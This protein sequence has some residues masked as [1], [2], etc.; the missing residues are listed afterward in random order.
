MTE[1]LEKYPKAAKVVRE[2]YLE[3]LLESLKEK[4]LPD[5]FKE[6][7]KQQGITDETVQGLVSGNPVLLFSV[8]DENEIYID[9]NVHKMAMKIPD[10]EIGFSFKILNQDSILSF[11]QTRKQAEQAAVEKSFELL[12]QKL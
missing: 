3:Q 8:F 10:K 2:Y 11:Y 6:H 9:I 7:V 4:N 5:E 1:L 12:E